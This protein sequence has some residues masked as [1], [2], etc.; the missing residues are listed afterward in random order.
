[1]IHHLIPAMWIQKPD[2]VFHQNCAEEGG[3]DMTPQGVSSIAS[4]EQG[5]DG[6]GEEGV[7]LAEATLA[8]KKGSENSKPTTAAGLSSKGSVPESD[9]GAASLGRAALE[10]SDCGAASLG[11]AALPAASAKHMVEPGE[12]AGAAG[13]ANREGAKNARRGAVDKTSE[14]AS[15]PATASDGPG[16]EGDWS[17]VLGKPFRLPGG[18]AGARQLPQGTAAVAARGQQNAGMP[19]ARATAPII[20]ARAARQEKVANSSTPRAGP[21]AVAAVG[22]RKGKG[23]SSGRRVKICVEEDIGVREEVD[24]DEGR[25]G[26]SRFFPT[27]VAVGFVSR[28]CRRCRGS[29]RYILFVRWLDEVA[30]AIFSSFA[31]TCRPT[32]RVLSVFPTLSPGSPGGQSSVRSSCSSEFSSNHILSASMD[33]LAADS[34]L[35]ATPRFALSVPLIR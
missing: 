18:V 17:V 23:S 29:S 2:G 21:P 3:D 24:G 32:W 27:I 4:A 31:G 20:R 33:L 5:T 6:R 14:P 7:E 12:D 28:T 11:R 22:E 1:V 30:V 26:V 25:F 15:G 35:M 19:A 16:D 9:C 13:G 8:A 10:E 34:T